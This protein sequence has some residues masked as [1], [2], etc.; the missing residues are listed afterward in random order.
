MRAEHVAAR[1]DLVYTTSSQEWDGGIIAHNN[2]YA[3]LQEHHCEKISFVSQQTEFGCWDL[4]KTNFCSS[5]N[6]KASFGDWM[7]IPKKIRRRPN[8]QIKNVISSSVAETEPPKAALFFAKAAPNGGLRLRLK[9]TV[10]L[11]RFF[12]IDRGKTA[13]AA[14]NWTNSAPQ[15][16]ATSFTLPSVSILLL[17]PNYT[18]LKQLVNYI[19]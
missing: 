4:Y 13:S 2:S 10:E 17:C 14:K 1:L 16:D 8:N 7:K 18:V 6:H 12:Q 11:N 15:T 19:I 3:F 9:Q 5:R